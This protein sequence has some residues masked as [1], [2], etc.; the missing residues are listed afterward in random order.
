MCACVR[1]CEFECVRA[2][3][4]ARVNL[5][6]SVSVSVCECVCGF[7]MMHRCYGVRLGCMLVCFT[8]MGQE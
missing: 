4:F 1:V 2:C 7:Y 5:S 8:C 3:V 6:V